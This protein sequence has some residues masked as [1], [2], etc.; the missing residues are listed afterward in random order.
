[1]ATAD[2]MRTG[3]GRTWI[4]T[5]V[6]PQR[7]R[8]GCTGTGR[9]QPGRIF[10]L[11][12][13]LSIRR[14]RSVDRGTTASGLRTKR[15]RLSSTH[16]TK[17]TSN[18]NLHTRAERI[19]RPGTRVIYR[20]RRRVT[21]ARLCMRVNTALSCTRSER[22][23]RSRG[24]AR[25]AASLGIPSSSTSRGR[26]CMNRWR[27]RTSTCGASR[28]SKTLRENSMPPCSR[29]STTRSG[30]SQPPSIGPG[31][32]TTPSSCCRQTTAA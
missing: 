31:S 9:W 18:R 12:M 21:G 23:K 11:R 19:G 2:T 5:N 13:S 27:R 32:A 10:S 22:W 15:P 17:R 3:W 24:T 20:P 14:R 29:L 16:L 30:T 4:C 25:V 26:R 6:G 1:M 7:T 8:I 28:T